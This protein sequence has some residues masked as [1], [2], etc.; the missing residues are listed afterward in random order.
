MVLEHFPTGRRSKIR[1]LRG[2]SE[3]FIAIKVRVAII[4]KLRRLQES[5][6]FNN[7]ITLMKTFSTGKYLSI[8][9]LSAST[10]S[11]KCFDEICYACR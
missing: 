6:F 4:W 7:E 5:F 1:L 8:S 9:L 2:F 10:G 11:S 3:V